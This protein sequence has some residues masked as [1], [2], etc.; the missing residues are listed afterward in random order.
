MAEMAGLASQHYQDIE[1]GRR[2]DLMLSTLER[3]AG[4]V[5]VEVWALLKP[6]AFPEPLNKRGRSSFRVSR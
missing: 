4:A 2:P 5:G 3:L 6:D 1:A